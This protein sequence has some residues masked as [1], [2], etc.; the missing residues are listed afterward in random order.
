[1]ES[2]TIYSVSL[3]VCF[4]AQH[5]FDAFIVHVS[6]GRMFCIVY[7]HTEENVIIY[8]RNELALIRQLMM[9]IKA[10]CLVTCQFV[11]IC[12]FQQA[13]HVRVPH[14]SWLV[15][16]LRWMSPCARDKQ[17]DGKWWLELMSED[18]QCLDQC[19]RARCQRFCHVSDTHHFVCSLWLANK[20]SRV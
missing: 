8:G 14:W 3:N 4:S 11:W 5:S 7:F 15:C 16:S 2:Q 13:N 10:I 6:L 17:T 18:G 9:S 19:Y 20:V 12:Q 1:M